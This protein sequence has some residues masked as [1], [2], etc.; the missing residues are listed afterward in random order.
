MSK[1]LWVAVSILLVLF[2]LVFGGGAIAT[3]D[4]EP[5]VPSGKAGILAR[6][7]EILGLTEEQLVNAFKQAWGEMKEEWRASHN[8]TAT[9][10]RTFCKEKASRFREK[11]SEKQRKWAEKEKRWREKRHKWLEQKQKWL[12]RW[13]D[14]CPFYDGTA[15]QNM[16]LFPDNSNTIVPSTTIY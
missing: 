12:E 14:R 13:R 7:A 3:A 16:N 6:V 8:C 2:V 9:D 15:N 4:D 10:N 11:L 5:V 1:K